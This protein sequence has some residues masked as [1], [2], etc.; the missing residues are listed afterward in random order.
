MYSD[1]FR[2]KRKTTAANWK[3]RHVISVDDE[4]YAPV[5]GHNGDSV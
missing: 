1:I 4:R 3:L 2:F 5:E